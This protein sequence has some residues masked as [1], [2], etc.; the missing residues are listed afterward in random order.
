[1]ERRNV[2][3]SIFQNFKIVN[4]KIT[5]DELFDSF[6][7]EFTFFIFYTLFENNYKPEY[8]I[9]LSNYKILIFQIIKFKKKLLNF[10][11]SIIFQIKQ[12]RIFDHFSNSSITANL[13]IG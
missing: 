12:F 4:I 7:I 11:Y 10:G 8:L 3:Q 2:E 1:M 9:I 13:E 6:I 5:K